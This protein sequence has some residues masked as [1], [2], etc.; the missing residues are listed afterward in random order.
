[1]APL[2]PRSLQH[3][4]ELRSLLSSAIGHLS[5]RTPP[6]DIIHPT[7]TLKPRSLASVLRR[8]QVTVTA[9]ASS[10][11]NPII[12]ATYSG[13]NTGPSP[14]EVAGIVFGS[15]A[16]FLLLLWLI[17]TCFTIGSNAPVS[18]VVDEDVTVRR[19]SHSSRRAPSSHTEITEVRT[20]RERSESRGVSRSRS[21]PPVR[22]PPR[23]ESSRRETVI[24]EETRRAS[25]PP[26]QDDIVE[27]I[28][29]HSPVRS[30][31]RQSR[32]S[33]G[34]QS[35]YRTVDPDAFGGG[36]RPMRKVSSRR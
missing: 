2:L 10:T 36:D 26:P 9:T 35:G 19:H 32:R 33:S 14:G 17:Y 16:G 8:Q 3:P 11:A 5:E 27:V 18:S 6:P 22:S 4:P 21:P 30:P 28:E 20:T 25:R 31:Q 1:M 34:R 29:E 7:Q 13:L 15:V 24:I 12:P 23:R